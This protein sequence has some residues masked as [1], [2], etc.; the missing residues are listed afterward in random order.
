[1]EAQVLAVDA[2]KAQRKTTPPK[3]AL[4][5]LPEA[6]RFRQLRPESKHFIDTIKMI[7]YRAESALAG[8]SART[9]GPGGR[10][11]GPPGHPPTCVTM[12]TLRSNCTCSPLQDAAVAN[13]CEELTATETMFPTTSLRLI[14]LQVGST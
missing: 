4:K 9:S 14:Y 12:G 2:L 13:L 8:G 3:V 6:E 5:E 11:A 7:A 1:M 10:C